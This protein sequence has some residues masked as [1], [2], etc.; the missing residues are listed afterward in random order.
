M[1][2]SKESRKGASALLKSCLNAGV[3]DEGKVSQVLQALTERQPTGLSQILREYHRL[4][5]LHIDRRTAVVESAQSLPAAQQTN[6]RSSLSRRFG[7]D[8]RFEFRVNPEL[9]GGIKIRVGSEVFEASV[10]ERLN[11]LQYE[12]NH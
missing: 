6:L 8:L 1:K 9:I 2:V 4:V 12:L 11:R 7:A 10:K 5:R 3:L